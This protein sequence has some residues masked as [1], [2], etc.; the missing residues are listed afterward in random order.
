[1]SCA[2]VIAVASV[3]REIVIQGPERS[4]A[5]VSRDVNTPVDAPAS[6]PVPAP[7]QEHRQHYDHIMRDFF[8]SSARQRSGALV[9]HKHTTAESHP[10]A[11][12]RLIMNN[13]IAPAVAHLKLTAIIQGPQPRAFINDGFAR[14]GE[15]IRIDGFSEIVF[16]VKAIKDDRVLLTFGSTN[17]VLK[18]IP[19]QVND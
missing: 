18:L 17:V 10:V 3:V 15:Q 1:M 11:D 7:V 16:E 2:L 4:G 13:E 14:I 19:E 6:D 5:S 12:R 9:K 8:V